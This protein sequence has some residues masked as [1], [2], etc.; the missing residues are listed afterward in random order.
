MKEYESAAVLG[1]AKSGIKCATGT[2][3]FAVEGRKG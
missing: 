3:Q 1:G 2:V